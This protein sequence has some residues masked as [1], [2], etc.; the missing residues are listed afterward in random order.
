MIRLMPPPR[1]PGFRV[2][3]RK[4]GAMV[5]GCGKLCAYCASD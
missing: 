3:S 5:H 2:S 4:I 1:F